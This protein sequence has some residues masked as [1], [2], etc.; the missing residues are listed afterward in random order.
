MRVQQWKHIFEKA[1]VT[2]LGILALIIFL[3]SL[4]YIARQDTV[5]L[6]RDRGAWLCIIPGICLLIYFVNF[7]FKCIDNVDLKK[8]KV[9]FVIMG[10][11]IVIVQIIVLF[12]I[13][14]SRG[15][16][17]TFC[18][19]DEAMTMLERKRSI[20]GNNNEYFSKYGNNYFITYVLYR[21]F[22]LAKKFNIT[23]FDK[24]LII[25]NILCIDFSIL[26]SI[27]IA[28]L[29]R[30]DIFSLKMLFLI[31]IC[32]TTYLWLTFTYTN[33]VSMFFIMAALYYG[34]RAIAGSG[35]SYIWSIITGFLIAIGFAIR[36]T[37]IIP[38]IALCMMYILFEKH[39]V[40]VKE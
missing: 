9:C 10:A 13:T 11:I 3:E 23:C 2:C 18:V 24:I 8:A 28:K 14:N 4:V 29:L 39:L 12:F 6:N 37:T 30:G 27:R 26:Y 36:A 35:K 25:L 5:I 33:T 40:F 34:I 1:V 19:I 32:P 21:I 22:Q 16:T 20:I 7:I 31:Q 15:I 38:L 17:D